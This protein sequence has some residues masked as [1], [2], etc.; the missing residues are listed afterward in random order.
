MKHKIHF[1]IKKNDVVQLEITGMTAEGW[2]VGRCEEI[3]VFVPYT[4]IGDIIEAKILKVAKTYAFGKMISL[5][6]ASQDRIEID[7]KHFTKCGGCTYR[8]MTYQAELAVKE[9]RVKDALNRIGGFSD[10][11]MEP[12]VGAKQPDHYRNKAQLP[13]GIDDNHSMIMGFYSNRSHR[14]IN[15]ESCALQ[16]QSFTQAMD[17]FREWADTSGNDVYQE[18]TGKGRM[19]HL[20]LREAGATGEVM[21]CVVVNGNGLYHE[22]TLVKQLRGHVHG[23]KSVIINSNRENTNVILGKKCRT[24]WGSDT[25]KDTLCGLTF[26]IS[27]LS[28]YQ[29]NRVQTENLYAIAKEYAGLTGEEILLD[30]YCGTGTI[31]LSMA[32]QAKKLIGVE[33]IE[34]AV[35]NARKN[36]QVNGIENAEFIC[37]DAASAAE[38]LEQQGL[39][40]NAIVIDP[41]RKGCDQSLI[42]T[43]SRMSPDRVV[44]VSCDPATL[45][46]DLKW[47]TEEGYM[48]QEVTPVDMFPR[49]AHVETVVQLVRKTP[50]AHIDLKIDM[51]EIDI[52]SAESKATYEKIKQYIADK[53]DTKVSS[54]YIAQVK[55]KHGI[56][57]RENYNRAKSADAKQPQC[58]PEK[59]KMIEDALQYFKMV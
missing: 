3:A 28:F 51:D 25:I 38:M 17:A 48:P 44:Y 18:Q 36:A 40:P 22:D 50:D 52:T 37:G 49:T 15:C 29:V 46:R 16:P 7:C 30:L 21:A 26:H 32:Y 43:I 31:G 47:F 5:I 4:A 2:G 19:R 45:A 42:K 33:V 35:E 55:E 59:E 6:T 57:E 10:L 12:I 9:Q 54:L 24:V 39:R 11:P 58:P 23:L 1:H 27:P 53:Y 13:I 14:I 41:P 34:A 20:Y 8:H 56:I